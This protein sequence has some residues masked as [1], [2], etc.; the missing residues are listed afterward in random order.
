MASVKEWLSSFAAALSLGLIAGT[1]STFWVG[2]AVQTQANRTEAVKEGHACWR[3]LPDGSTV[4]HW[5]APCSAV[6]V[7]AEK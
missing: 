5:N 6:P 2:A 1:L 4:F 3:V 7:K